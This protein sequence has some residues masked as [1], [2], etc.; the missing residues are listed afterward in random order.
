LY[1]R[2]GVSFPGA[3]RKLVFGAHPGKWAASKLQ[4]QQIVRP[5]V[6]TFTVT[7]RL[8]RGM[9]TNVAHGSER[10]FYRK[11]FMILIGYP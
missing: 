2:S 9:E 7:A 8:T 4:L 10:V 11:G 5:H 6:A 1:A 3:E